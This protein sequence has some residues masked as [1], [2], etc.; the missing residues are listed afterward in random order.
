MTKVK[1]LIGYSYL[2]VDRRMK[3]NIRHLVNEEVDKGHTFTVQLK[4][5]LCLK[6]YRSLDKA[7]NYVS[8]IEDFSIACFENLF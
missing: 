2:T 6:V 3:V 7:V 1:L 4:A 5:A 8:L